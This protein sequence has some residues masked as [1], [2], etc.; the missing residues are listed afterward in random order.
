M[1]KETFVKIWIFL[2]LFSAIGFMFMVFLSS[3]SVFSFLLFLIGASILGI[4]LSIRAMKDKIKYSKFLF[5]F[6][7]IGMFFVVYFFVI[8]YFFIYGYFP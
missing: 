4:P 2:I 7:I 5:V 8:P 3:G 1:E 6:S